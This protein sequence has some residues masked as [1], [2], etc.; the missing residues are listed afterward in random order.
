[1]SI[2]CVLSPERATPEV[3]NS[4]SP[5]AVANSTAVVFPGFTTILKPPVTAE[6][7]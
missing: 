2:V 7:F 1:M 3:S 4:T 5:P 6:Y